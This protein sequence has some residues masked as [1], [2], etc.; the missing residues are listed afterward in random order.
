MAVKATVVPA[1]RAGGASHRFGSSAPLEAM[2]PSLSGPGWRAYT[3]DFRGVWLATQEVLGA[4]PRWT[5]RAA[6]PRR[7]EV[8]VEVRPVLGGKSR[9]MLL[10]L[11]L[12]PFGLT[13]VEIFPLSPAGE[14]APGVEK[15]WLQRFFRRLDARL[16]SRPA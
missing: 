2:D 5:V 4:M 11:S 12:D 6:D 13:R 7:G 16:H 9:P 3:V 10:R 8:E 1:A 14:P 15:P